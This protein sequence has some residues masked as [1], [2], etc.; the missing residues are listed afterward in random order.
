V[1]RVISGVR[2]AESPEWLKNKLIGIG[3]RPVNNVADITNL[4]LYELGHPM[5]AFD[6]DKV[7][8]H[9]I[10]VRRAKQGEALTTI[11]GVERKLDA[12]HLV[13]ADAKRPVGLAGVMG[14]LESEI[15]PATKNVLLES[16]YFDPSLI[17]RESHALGLKTDAS[18]RFERGADPNGLERAA[19]RC[20]KLIAQIAGGS[21]AQ[22]RIDVS[23]QKYQA[24]T[25]TLRPEK[26]DKLLGIAIPPA[27]MAEILTNLELDAKLEHGVITATIP[28]FRRDLER[29]ADLI[30]EVGRIHGYDNLPGEPIAPWGVP[31]LRRPKDIAVERV[32]LAMAALGFSEHVGLTLIDPAKLAKILTAKPGQLVELS[33]P[34]SADLSVL[35]PLLLP[36]LLDAALRNLNNGIADVRLYEAG[37]VFERAGG[38]QPRQSWQ[39]AGLACGRA[40]GAW[41]HKDRDY[42]FF[43]LKGAVASLFAALQLTVDIVGEE[44][45]GEAFLHPGRRAGLMLGGARIGC[46]GELA[47]QVTR[48]FDLKARCHY[49]QADLEPVIAALAAAHSQFAELPRYPASRRDLALVVR[50]DAACGTLAAVIREAGGAALGD[51]RLFDLYQGPQVKAGHK[52]M[53]F[54]LTFRAADRTLTDDEVNAACQQIVTALQQRAGAEVRTT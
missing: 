13:I 42:D 48:A 27:R 17:R 20:A 35:R 21:V 5:H 7:S 44:K 23:A 53:A 6:L 40:S 54:A 1:A 51:V 45:E 10:V 11:D 47:P 14:G 3:L 16:A 37:L 26:A 22:G 39:L 49:F 46:L 19:D 25:L 9:T 12:G 24:T 33:N 52:S 50:Q 15:S 2:V 29:E 30:E 8:E 38:E 4:V 41:D 43:D 31:G 36:D 32:S 28:T 18:Y 34:I